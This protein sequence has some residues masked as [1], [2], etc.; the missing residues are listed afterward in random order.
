MGS[1]IENLLGCFYKANGRWWKHKG[2]D[3]DWQE[4]S[5]DLND[6]L[7]EAYDYAEAYLEV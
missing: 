2:N 5:E 6:Y 1:L 3:G 4:V 7:D